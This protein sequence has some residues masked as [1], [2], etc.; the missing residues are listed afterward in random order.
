MVAD[1]TR[2]AE[3]LAWRAEADLEAAMAET[4]A[5]YRGRLSPAAPG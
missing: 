3:D 1:C 2:A 5:W 4:I